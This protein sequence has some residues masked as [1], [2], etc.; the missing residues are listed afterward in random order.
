M[1]ASTFLNAVQVDYDGFRKETL[2]MI[3]YV[4]QHQA[5]TP[6]TKTGKLSQPAAH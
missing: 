4:R 6:A 2:D 3:G 5:Q 1:N